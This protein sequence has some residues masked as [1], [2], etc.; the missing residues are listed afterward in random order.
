PDPG[1]GRGRPG[2]RRRAR[3]AR[4]RGLPRVL[5]AAPRDREVDRPATL[6]PMSSVAGWRAKVRD[7]F[8]LRSSENAIF[9]AALAVGGVGILV[10]A[11]AALKDTVVA[12]RFG[13]SD[14]LDAFVIAFLLITLALNVIA[15]ALSSAL[16]PTYIE[17]REREGGAAAQRLVAASS[18][19]TLILLAAG[20]VAMG[21]GARLVLP[22]I[23][24]GFSPEKLRLTRSLLLLMLPAF[25]L[26]GFA[27]FCGAILNAHRRFRLPV[28]V[29][30][31]ASAATVL[32]IAFGP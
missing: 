31:G 14:P 26:S 28:V 10:K 3:P 22:W 16:I 7:V 11:F 15:G 29:P 30:I 13:T 27:A 19:M 4:P 23:A 18:G 12:H 32:L 24:A 1:D 2:I 8:D 6:R 9:R 5:R 20:A 25:L 17:V 21:A